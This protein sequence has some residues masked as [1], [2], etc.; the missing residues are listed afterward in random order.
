MKVF[1]EVFLTQRVVFS[2]LS[3]KRQ[4]R[5]KKEKKLVSW[6]SEEI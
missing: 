3:I 1:I 4:I 5:V 6:R 2:V